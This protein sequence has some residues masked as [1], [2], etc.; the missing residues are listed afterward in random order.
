M[1][2]N[3]PLIYLLQ[4]GIRKP[5]RN[6]IRHSHYIVRFE[7]VYDP[8]SL[9]LRV[10]ELFRIAPKAFP[11]AR[12]AHKNYAVTQVSVM[13]VEPGIQR[14]TTAPPRH[15]TRLVDKIDANG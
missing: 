11:S 3:F 14:A 10:V 12:P 1:H 9:S 2:K 4:R 6:K 13:G 15:P 7:T 5:E 8:G